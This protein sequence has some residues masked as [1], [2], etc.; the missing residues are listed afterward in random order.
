VPHTFY[1]LDDQPAIILQTHDGDSFLN[2]IKQAG[3]PA[4][5]DAG[6][7]PAGEA[8][9]EAMLAIAAATG[10]PVIG[11]PMTPQEAEQI[12]ATAAAPV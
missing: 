12:Q 1:V 7:P 6:P 8:D 9:M 2:F 10:Q 4:G 11:P 5:A 3:V